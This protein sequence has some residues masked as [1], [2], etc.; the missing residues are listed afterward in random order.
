M[1]NINNV[2]NNIITKTNINEIEIKNTCC[3]CFD[4]IDN[5]KN[6]LITECEHKYHFSCM[7]SYII[8]S[9]N[10]KNKITCPICRRNLNNNIEEN[11]SNIIEENNSNNIEDEMINLFFNNT[12]S[13]DNSVYSINQYSDNEEIQYHSE[14]I[15]QQR[16]EEYL[17]TNTEENNE[18]NNTND[19]IIVNPAINNLL[20][21][22][23]LE[24][25]ITIAD[26]LARIQNENSIE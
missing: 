23:N 17:S 7:L 11:N 26:L 3:I 12:E 21:R 1:N 16:T 2:E 18:I 4:E 5:N 13:I 24:D 8:K 25:F 6:I 10:D 19:D 20:T 9:T 14:T 22:S 15:L